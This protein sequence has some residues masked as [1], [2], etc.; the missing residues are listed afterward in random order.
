MSSRPAAPAKVTAMAIMHIVGGV[1]A[2]SFAFVWALSTLFLY[3]PWVYSLVLGILSIVRGAR[4]LGASGR[5]AGNSNAVPIMQIINIICCDWVNLTMGIISL[6]FTSDPE[7]Y[8]YLDPRSQLEEDY[9][10]R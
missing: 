5:G 3:L 6:V 1:M 7:V 2:I 8:E 10:R 4:L 9:G